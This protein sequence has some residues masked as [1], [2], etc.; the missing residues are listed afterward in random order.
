MKKLL[1]LLFVTI[2]CLQIF[3]IP[4]NPKPVTITQSNGEELTLVIRG[5]EY[6]KWAETLDG[7]TLLIDS[8]SN[9]CYAQLNDSGD[10]EPSNI[11][12]TEIENRPHAVSVW[13]Q[14]INKKLFYSDSQVYYYMQ[15]REINEMEIEKTRG[16]TIGINKVPVILMGFTDRPFRK[17]AADFDMIFN[18]INYTDNGFRG[19]MK[20]FFLESSYNKLEVQCSIFGPYIAPQTAVW[21]AY[22][23]PNGSNPR[24][25]IFAQD[26][27]KA[28]IN[29]GVNFSEFTVEGGNQIEGLY[30]IYAGYDESNGG[31][32]CIWAH[33]QLSFNWNYGGFL[34]KRYA[35]SSELRGTSGTTI[36]NIGTFCH[37]YG[38]VLGALDYYDTNYGTWGEYDGT[39]YWDLQASG[40]HNDNSRNPAHPNPR[41]KVYTYGW[42]TAI[43][44][45]TPQ[46]CTIPVS[47][48]YDNAFYR[49]NTPK[50]NEYFIIENKTQQ[51]FDS[52]IPGKN[53]LIYRC[54][55]VYE[56]NHGGTNPAVYPQ[57][58]TSYQRFYPVSA[59][60][61]VKVPEF[62]T[63]KQSQYGSINSSLCTWPQ[64]NQLA[65][66]NT[67]TPAMVTW[68]GTSVNKPITN[69]Q[70]FEDYIT[71]N[72]MGGGNKS[73]FH[74]FLPAYYGCKI[75][76]Q[77]GS[78][79]PVNE[80]GSFSFKLELLPSH[81]KSILVVTANKDTLKP[82]AGIY[83]ISN[84]KADQ[85]VRISGLKFNTFPVTVTVGANGTITPNGDVQV[86][87]GGMQTFEI[88]AD[89][90]YSIDKVVVDGVDKGKIT[91]HTFVNVNEPHAI[92]ATFK[93]GD[94]YTINT[95][96]QEAYFET[97]QGIPTEK[98]EAVVSSS[99]IIGDVTI[100]A[101]NRFQISGDN[102]K[103]WQQAFKVVKNKLPYTFWIRFYPSWGSS[104]AGTFNEVL[105]LLSTDAYAEI[106]LTGLSHLGI[107]DNALENTII[108]YPNPTT[109]KLKIES[110][111]LRIEKIEIC[112]IFGKIVLSNSS[113]YQ[114]LDISYLST[115][116][117]IMNIHTD[118]GIVHKK[119]VKE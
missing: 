104:N 52:N 40:A 53:L 87:E 32:D 57:N 12:A 69:I 7:Y 37:E 94:I 95:S 59:N 119:V 41:S 70:V 38:H 99:D 86:N 90:G 103:N 68:D 44:L 71:F 51:G 88:K 56:A 1:I 74:V 4:A 63:N 106:K 97:V 49:I 26:A 19:S 114:E 66:T 24:Y 79:S 17:T 45:N 115:G 64:N 73:N 48:T 112:D 14:N 100:T 109:G 47:R 80:G 72:F 3:A 89:I 93:K 16:G 75:T 54:T 27:I 15:L 58:M 105:K 107:D 2:V 113:F 25:H 116:V 8:E 76:P 62:G 28:A 29:A 9:F 96:I 23:A 92:S 102:G 77:S 101:P 60:A 35:A 61:K 18:Q 65:F 31:K 118:K 36:S 111:A 83:T 34:F 55:D 85:I 33:A 117:Y 110:G 42:A 10:L 11:I 43:E 21:Y 5:D 6:I 50:S 108:I 46:R 22:K 98:V 78:I 20:D 67:S 39:G 84:I 30:C 81:N 91:S 82:A 13:L